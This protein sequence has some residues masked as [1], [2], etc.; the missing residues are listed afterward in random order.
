MESREE[1]SPSMKNLEQ[2]VTLNS[3]PAIE[4]GETEVRNE[5]VNNPEPEQPVAEVQE[6]PVVVESQ[7]EATPADADV[8]AIESEETA[9]LEEDETEQL[10]VGF[11][12][13]DKAQLVDKLVQ[14]VQ[15]PI[16][17][18][19]GEVAAIKAA[20]YALR[21]QE[22]AA[23]KEEFLSR[24][25][26]E[27]AFA[28]REDEHENRLK[29][30]LEM[31]K[32][33]RAEYNAAQEAIKAENL[34]KKRDIIQQIEEITNDPDN[35]NRQFP[36]CSN[37]S[38]SLRLRALYLPLAK[39]RCGRLTNLLSRSSMTC[40]RLIRSCATTISRRTLK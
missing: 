2:D 23:E 20:F 10:N 17:T 4:A 37:C 39:P 13:M 31:V 22:L 38:R 28:P 3:E 19:K 15:Q 11:A 18:I 12:S 30:L 24:G 33:K 40:S 36:V 14:V 5:E 9:E 16:E 21:K 29:E 25:N 27:S 1:M 26:E 32:E 6:Q 8:P 34:Q 7:D 35:I